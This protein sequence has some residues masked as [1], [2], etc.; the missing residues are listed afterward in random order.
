MYTTNRKPEPKPIRLEPLRPRN[1]RLKEVL[2][3]ELPHGYIKSGRDKSRHRHRIKQELQNI[4][5]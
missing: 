5:E 3:F 4:H 1:K 2:L